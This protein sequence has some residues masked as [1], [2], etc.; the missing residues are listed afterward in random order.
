MTVGVEEEFLLLDAEKS[1][2]APA[3]DAVLAGLPEGLRD[4]VAHEYLTSQIEINSPPAQDL[5]A[6]RDSMAVLRGGVAHAAARAGVRVVPIGTCP[7]AGPEPP[8]V[9]QPRFRRMVERFGALSPGPGLNGLHVHVG[10]PDPE[11]GV[12]VLNHLRPWLPLL[13]AATTNSPFADGHDTGY[14]S[15]RSI[16]WA[17]WPSVGPTPYL[18]SYEHYQSL[19]A[20]L[21]ATG[22]MLDEA[23]LY[24]YARLSARFPTV[25]IRIGDV[26]PTLDD[27]ILIA[28][29]IRALVGTVLGDVAAGRPAPHV[30]HHVLAAAHWRAAHDGLAGLAVDPATRHTRPA[31]HLLTRLFDT[32]RPELERNGDR[33]LATILMGRLRSR[34][35]GANRQRAVYARTGDMSAVLD[36]LA[37]RGV[38]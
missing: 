26:C 19:V 36:Y 17:R 15:W 13:H 27:T 28:A 21:I 18:E 1:Q 20:D 16:M 33:E 8:V 2:A 29:L 14:A 11:T 24:W 38:G 31:W 9:D 12:Q 22:A 34:G 6:L 32:V 10:V 5:A 25:E 37:L 7:V 23:M 30:A 4:Q 3:V 35:T